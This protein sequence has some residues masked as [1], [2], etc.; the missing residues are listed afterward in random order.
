MKQELLKSTSKTWKPNFDWMTQWRKQSEGINYIG[1]EDLNFWKI[2]E[3]V[4]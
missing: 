4:L 2:L 1:M 3:E